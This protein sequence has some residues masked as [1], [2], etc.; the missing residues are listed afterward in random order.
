MTQV[1]TFENKSASELMKDISADMDYLSTLI[2][3]MAAYD[4]GRRVE[5]GEDVTIEME[6]FKESMKARAVAKGM[7]E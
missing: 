6:Q 2:V 4:F 7:V 5:R 1:K 3:F